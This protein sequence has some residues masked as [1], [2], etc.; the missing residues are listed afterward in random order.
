MGLSA[1][2]NQPGTRMTLFL[3][4][5]L[6]V[7]LMS[8]L[9]QLEHSIKN[10]FVMDNSY[11]RPS[12]FLFD[13]QEDQ[14]DEL[15][16]MVAGH[17]AQM[18]SL[19]PLIRAR[20][21]QVNQLAFEKRLQP[22]EALTREEEQ[23]ARMRNRGLNL[24]YRPTLAQSEQIIEGRPLRDE[25][26]KT[27]FSLERKY[28][29]RMGIKMGDQLTLDVQGV[30]VQG[31]VVNL[32]KVRWTSFEPNFFILVNESTLK[33]AP[34]VWL[35]GVS[36]LLEQNKMA[37]Q[38]ELAQKQSNVSVIDVERVSMDL[39]EWVDKISW[40]FTGMS[41]LTLLVGFFVLL[42][43]LMVQIGQRAQEMNLYHILGA[44]RRDLFQILFL[45]YAVT[46]VLALASGALLSV[47]VA[48]VLSLFIFDK[49]VL[50]HAESL[51]RNISLIGVSA[52]ILLAL[53]LLIFT[54]YFNNKKRALYRPF[55]V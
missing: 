10:E 43:T 46:I 11:Q 23:E 8:L 22:S 41:Y 24:S 27:E 50:I 6:T 16:N 30:E 34:K 14:L 38:N 35:A 29:E 26:G 17:Q 37:F 51:G 42:S 1:L 15:K 53:I 4:L 48:E 25:A 7:V 21:L 49:H 44:G 5:S 45:E 33:E 47:L 18:V 9:P 12:L 2:L 36:Q 40:T 54:N 20:L 52:L 31:T 32:R 19:S 39:F 55:F 3:C 28:A 13:I